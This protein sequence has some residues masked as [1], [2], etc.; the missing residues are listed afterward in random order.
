VVRQLEEVL[1]SSDDINWDYLVVAYE[2]IWAIGTGV[3]ATPDDAEQ[4][5]RVIREWIAGKFGRASAD[6]L[7]VVYGGSLTPENAGD[8]FERDGVDGGLVGGASL[9]F[10]SFD[11]IMSAAHVQ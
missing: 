3:N 4:M 11:Q 10:D 9:Q 7:R 1:H 8:L 2:P 6:Q 5:H